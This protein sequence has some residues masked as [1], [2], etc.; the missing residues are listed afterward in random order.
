M[1]QL[2]SITR[3]VSGEPVARFG[4]LESWQDFTG[5]AA[6][7]QASVVTGM[8]SVGRNR[9]EWFD[10]GEVEESIDIV[11]MEEFTS[12]FQDGRGAAGDAVAGC[13]RQRFVTGEAERESGD[14]CVSGA[15][16]AGD[17]DP[18]RCDGERRVVARYE[19]CTIGTERDGEGLAVPVVEEAA[20]C[21]FVVVDSAEFVA[22]DS[23]EFVDAWFD[24]CRVCVDC[25]EQAGP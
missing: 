17:V 12:G 3:R 6:V 20:S 10:R 25:L 4:E 19:Q 24:E 16:G 21:G 1:S 13:A 14:H 7:V 11:G 23:A 9:T 18:W 2:V 5:G 22:D 8:Q 15:A